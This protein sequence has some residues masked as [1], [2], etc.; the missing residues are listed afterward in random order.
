[1]AN[2][3][4]LNRAKWTQ[5]AREAYHKEHPENFAGPSMSFPIKDGGDVADAW[6]LAGHA[7]HP[8]AVRDNIKA[9]ARR[10]GLE[11]SLPATAK[12]D[13]NERAM[14]D[15]ISGVSAMG[16]SPVSAFNQRT[17]T[18]PS[19]QK[20][21]RD[22]VVS[23]ENMSELTHP[24]YTGTHSHPHQH[25]DGSIVDHAHPH[26]EDNQHECADY[27]AENIPHPRSHSAVSP[28]VMYL[29]ITRSD[30]SERMVYGQAT[31]EQPDAYGTI[32]GYCPDA[33]KKWRGN[34]REQHDPRKAVGK[35]IR[36]EHDEQE[37]AIYVGS[38]ISRGAQDTWLKVEDGVLSGYSASIVPDP[39]FGNDIHKWPKKEYHGKQYPYLP[40]YS[41]VELSLV[42]NPATPGCNISIIRANGMATEIL[43]TTEE[44]IPHPEPEAQPISRAGARVSAPTREKMHAARDASLMAARHS[45]DNCGCDECQGHIK[46]LDPDMDGDV[47]LPGSQADTDHDAQQIIKD[48]V[49]RALSPAFVR[50]QALAGEFARRNTSFTTA[51]DALTAKLDTVLERV[52]N[53]SSLDEV[54]SVL[55]EVKD[56]VAVIAAQPAAGGPVLNGQ[57]INKS[58]PNSPYYPPVDATQ[59][60]LDRMQ[61][62]GALDTIDKQVA[63][64]ALA[65][66]PMYGNKG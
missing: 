52:A 42:D 55:T 28:F 14:S 7:D 49:E 6:G 47:D 58:L 54:R 33:W 8:D 57:G 46:R 11:S 25:A 3:Y 40:R 2:I 26:H 22:D 29:P 24:P 18:E 60:V 41:V 36:V 61:Q 4:T 45:M 39:E 37:R 66:R 50:L 59:A 44:E 43:D 5:A 51:I 64:A 19:T 21:V 1:M 9:I 23:N 65:V 30:S 32:F 31:I 62:M 16:E 15:A 56:Q 20:E 53:T 27:T 63:A 38:K 17:P 35:A 12:D 13:S 48:T 10:L 34:I